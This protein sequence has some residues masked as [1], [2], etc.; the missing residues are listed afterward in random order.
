[1]KDVAQGLAYLHGLKIIHGDV[2]G[3]SLLGRR[4]S[5]VLQR[6]SYYHSTMSSSVLAG[7]PV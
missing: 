4:R 1:M 3:V 6:V 2:K 5:A 7:L